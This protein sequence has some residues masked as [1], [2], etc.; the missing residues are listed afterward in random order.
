[1]LKILLPL[2][3]TQEKPQMMHQHWQPLRIWS[4]RQVRII[5]KYSY[6]PAHLQQQ[7]STITSHKSP[8]TS[9]QPPYWLLLL[10]EPPVSESLPSSELSL[11]PASPA[12]SEWLVLACHRITST[13]YFPSRRDTSTEHSRSS[14]DTL[15]TSCQ[16]TLA[17]ILSRGGKVNLLPFHS[18]PSLS[19][20]SSPLSPS[21]YLL[22]CPLC[23]FFSAAKRI[24]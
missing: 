3:V 9:E 24:P 12:G 8:Q 5:L 7:F 20:H 22:P 17:G 4:V 19:L 14:A 6:Y 15:T 2:K 21:P 16:W 10:P 1:M 23:P 18:I 11:C 13:A